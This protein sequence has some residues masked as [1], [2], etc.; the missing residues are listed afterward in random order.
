MVRRPSLPF[1]SLPVHR[2]AAGRNLHG[3][4]PR[5]RLPARAGL[6]AARRRPGLRLDRR[7]RLIRRHRSTAIARI[8]RGRHGGMRLCEQL[9]IYIRLAI[10]SLVL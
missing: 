4:E 6:R 7:P 1:P 9:V 8:F 2:R 10:L 5:D 3:R